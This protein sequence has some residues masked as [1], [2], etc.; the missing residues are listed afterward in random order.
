MIKTNLIIK[1]TILAIFVSFVKSSTNDVPDSLN[2]GNSNKFG[3]KDKP[4]NWLSTV[5]NQNLPQY[6]QS[7]WAHAL[8]STLSDRINIQILDGVGVEASIS[9]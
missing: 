2:W 3:T 8:T 7:Q 9:P 1:I 5:K 4:I 6:C